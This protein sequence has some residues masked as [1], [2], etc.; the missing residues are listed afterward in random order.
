[1]SG[2]KSALIKSAITQMIEI[3]TKKR[4]DA[5]NAGGDFLSF[6]LDGKTQMVVANTAV[7]NITQNSCAEWAC[8]AQTDRTTTVT[9][10][11]IN[12]P[13][14]APNANCNAGAELSTSQGALLLM[15]NPAMVDSKVKRLNIAS[16]DIPISMMVQSWVF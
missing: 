13:N 1:V 6:G 14:A 3:V 8:L 15:P 10:E 16:E 2:K 7:R 5:D 4:A 11:T 9:I 12:G